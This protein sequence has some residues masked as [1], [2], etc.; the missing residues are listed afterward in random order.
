MTVTIGHPDVVEILGKVGFDYINFD[1]QHAPLNIETVQMMM[2]ALG[3]S[4]STPIVRVPWNDYALINSVLDIGA[5]GVIIPFVNTRED[6]ERAV[7]AAS[8]PPKGMRSYGPRRA[9]FIY[10]N[11]VS[12]SDEE[13]LVIP[14]IETKE[15]IENLEDILSVERVEAFF[16]GPY[17]LS[18][19]LGVFAQWEHPIME[20]A[21]MKIIEV[22]ESS[23]KKAGLLAPIEDVRKTLK[24][25]FK[26]ITIG[27]DF[28]YLMQAATESLQEAK[29]L[30]SH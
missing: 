20:K 15:A 3:G 12:T 19:S 9:S 7:W 23:G 2:Q 8:Y 21:L 13:I 30:M 5:Q 11:Y 4:Q 24:R 1:M 26:L 10:P 27:R 25:G 16:V 17:D 22:A 14:Q 6:L 28:G 18:M 29:S